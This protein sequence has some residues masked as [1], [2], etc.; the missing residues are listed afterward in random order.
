MGA[1]CGRVVLGAAGGMRRAR[2][3]QCRAACKHQRSTR[4]SRSDERNESVGH[5]RL[6]SPRARRA[7]DW[8]VVIAG[9]QGSRPRRRRRDRNPA[10]PAPAAT[11]S[12]RRDR[13][14]QA[15]PKSPPQPRPLPTPSDYP[16]TRCPAAAPR[17]AAAPRS[18]PRAAG[19]S[20]TA[21]RRSASPSAGRC[22]T[23]PARR[24]RCADPVAGFAAFRR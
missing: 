12:R 1:R 17:A 23:P 21:S 14:S 4:R 7:D 3:G 18:S 24:W 5:Q 16:T 9:A 10:A 20:R 2:G 11:R 19:A 22:R 6:C 8:N 15:V 13:N